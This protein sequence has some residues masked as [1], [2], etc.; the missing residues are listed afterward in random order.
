MN[1][2]SIL[3][4]TLF[5]FPIVHTLADMGKLEKTVRQASLRHLGRVRHIQKVRAIEHLWAD[6]EQATSTLPVAWDKTRLYQDGLPICGRE[7]EI[8]GEL[9]QAG[10]RNHQIL[11]G[12][13]GKGA[14]L[15]GTESPDL[16]LQEYQLAQQVLA[17]QAAPSVGSDAHSRKSGSDLLLRKRDQFIASRINETLNEGES[18]ILFLGVLHSLEEYLEKDMKVIFPLHNPLHRI[19]GRSRCFVATR[20]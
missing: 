7:A 19:K 12:L 18:G 10:S 20:S 9:A 3:P 1:T 2:D 6:I 17:A 5:Y 8:V 11:M 14:M 16:L 15:M 4:R 13:M